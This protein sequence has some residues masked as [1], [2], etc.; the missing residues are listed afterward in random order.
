MPLGIEVGLGPSD[1][2]L[3]GDS[4]PPSPESGAEP[5]NFWPMSV[6]AKR[7]CVSGYH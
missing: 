1:S 6:V 2:V 5:P 3:H 4:A 7:L